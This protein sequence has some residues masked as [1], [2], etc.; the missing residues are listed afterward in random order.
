MDSHHAH[1]L[2]RYS[3]GECGECGWSPLTTVRTDNLIS[4][5]RHWLTGTGTGTCGQ[6][7]SRGVP[8]WSTMFPRRFVL[9]RV[10]LTLYGWLLPFFH[11]L[12]ARP[13]RRQGAQYTGRGA[14]APPGHGGPDGTR[15]ISI[16]RGFASGGTESTQPTHIHMLDLQ[17]LLS[18]S[19]IQAMH[20]RASLTLHCTS[21]SSASTS[22][23]SYIEDCTS[24]C[25]PV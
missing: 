21:H 3:S 13:G 4:C 23:H 25:T 2:S 17:H 6:A 12:F 16:S 19:R 10:T 5:G 15:A 22:I 11:S 7:D 18:I 1:M 20:P 9:D 14:P 24:T 8:H